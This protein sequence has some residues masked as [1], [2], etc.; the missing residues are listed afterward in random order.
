VDI[1]TVVFAYNAELVE[2]RRHFHRHPEE[3]G[4]EYATVAY[5]DNYLKALNISTITVEDGGL[6]GIIDS[7]KPGKTLLMRADIDALP[8][9]ES[10]NNLKCPKVCCSQVPGFSHSCGHDCHMAMTMIAGKILAKNKADWTGKVVLCF[11]RGEEYGANIRYLL[12]YLVEKS[13]LNIDGCYATHV[14]WDIPA[15]KVNIQSGAVMAGGLGFS[16][17]L[18]GTPGHGSR[19]DLANNPIDCFNAIY[20]DLAACPMRT[21]NPYDFL[22]FSIGQLEAGTQI[23]V[24]PGELTF[25][26]TSRFFN[27]KQAGQHFLDVLRRSVKHE[28]EIFGCKYEVLRCLDPLFE[29]RNNAPLSAL[30]K[31]AVA[32][33]LGQSVFFTPTP[34]MAS[35]S[36]ALY[37][38]EY[39]G[40]MTFT[41]IANPKTGAGANH[42]TPEFDI[43]E[44][45][46]TTGVIMAVSYA[47]AFLS[48]N[49][50][51]KFTKNPEPV[52]ILAARNI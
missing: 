30:C 51:P 19:P 7:G 35:E 14:R 23:N 6:L 37:L 33:E 10:P 39:P 12:P 46:L 36:Y 3:S 50:D 4:K 38:Q 44:A 2:L 48:S 52:E 40:I 32:K 47:L 17:K 31:K 27:L 42:H 15:G 29:V 25:G 49:I 11:E 21:V 43:D 28:C 16:I 45:G 20:N 22:T 34:W 9:A 8:V 13:G 26:G 5:I 24:I 1:K 18:I 41:G